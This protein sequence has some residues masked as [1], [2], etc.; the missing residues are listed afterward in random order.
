[1]IKSI[2]KQIEVLI[3]SFDL[4]LISSFIYVCC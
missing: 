2:E 3:G 4:Y 1:M